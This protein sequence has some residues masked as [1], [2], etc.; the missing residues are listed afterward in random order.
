MAGHMALTSSFIPL[1]LS[2]TLTLVLAQAPDESWTKAGFCNSY[3]CP[4]Y[5]ILDRT[6]DYEVRMYEPSVW[7]STSSR[8]NFM[9]FMRLFRYIS[10]NN[11]ESRKIAMTVPVLKR[12][13]TDNS[14]STMSF[15]VSPDQS[16]APQPNGDSVSVD[17]MPGQIVYVRSFG[18]FASSKKYKDHSDALTAALPKDAE[19]ESGFYYT[20]GYNS[21]WQM[22]NRHNE[23]WFIGK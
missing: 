4:S 5:E 21:P 18:G 22:N 19:Y 12:V 9:N 2:V 10:G 6:E 3:D 20:A 15:F 13:S 7:V 11:Q 23:V 1:I 17:S 14:P 16:P 8:S